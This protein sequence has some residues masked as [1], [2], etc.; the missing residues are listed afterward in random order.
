ME[1]TQ[2]TFKDSGVTVYVKKISPTVPM[3]LQRMFPP[4]KPPLQEVDYGEGR[5]VKEPNPAAPSYI[6]ELNKY[7]VDLESRLRKLMIKL[8]VSCTP[9]MDAV[10][11]FREAWLEATGQELEG[12][13]K[14][15]YVSY[16]AIQSESD[17]NDLLTA[18]LTKSQPTG[19][20]IQASIDNFRG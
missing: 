8:G 7:R 3:E 15:V 18:I 19:S 16:I 20:E 10:K 6:E 13:D 17:L 4:P 14:Y 12:D 1:L 5:I 11:E 9:D 2:F